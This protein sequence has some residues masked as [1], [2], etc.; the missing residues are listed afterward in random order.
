MCG[1]R[2]GGGGGGGGGEGG[3]VSRNNGRRI[4]SITRHC[5]CRFTT[6]YFV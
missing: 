6:I 1:P 3:G 5:P 2:G 4:N